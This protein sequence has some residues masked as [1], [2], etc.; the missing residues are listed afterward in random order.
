MFFSEK[1]QPRD[2]LP[3]DMPPEKRQPEATKNSLVRPK[4]HLSE[5][6]RMVIGKDM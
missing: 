2:R 3:Q 5:M 4:V 1:S 6:E